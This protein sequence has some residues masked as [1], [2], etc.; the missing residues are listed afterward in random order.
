MS[1]LMRLAHDMLEQWRY[2]RAPR[3]LFVS[4]STGV[5]ASISSDEKGAIV[6]T[7]LQDVL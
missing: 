4:V 6:S 7:T 5:T 2:I 3:R 1:S